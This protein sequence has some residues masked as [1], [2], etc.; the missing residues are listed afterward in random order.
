MDRTLGRRTLLKPSW[1]NDGRP[2]EAQR[3]PRTRCLTDGSHRRPSTK[4]KSHGDDQRTSR[5]PTAQRS[6]TVGV[7]TAQNRPSETRPEQH[8]CLEERSNGTGVDNRL[9]HHTFV[10]DPHPPGHGELRNR[11][12]GEP[13]V[14]WPL[15]R[16][17][18]R[19]S[20]ATSATGVALRR[21]RFVV[22]EC[23]PVVVFAN[24]VG[25]ANGCHVHN[26]ANT[27]L[28]SNELNRMRH[29][30][31]NGPRHFSIPQFFE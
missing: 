26:V 5:S 15:C 14:R 4:P 23:F 7:D 17:L 20:M 12:M 21:R 29:A 28:P 11:G 1:S 9:G 2:P 10:L 13:A 19:C 3:T 24:G 6:G 8:R 16:I 18:Y 31:E 27:V 22:D 30:F 25:R